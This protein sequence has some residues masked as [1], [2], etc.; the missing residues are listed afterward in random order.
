MKASRFF[1]WLLALSLLSASFPVFAGQAEVEKGLH[2]SLKD[3]NRIIRQIKSRAFDGKPVQKQLEQLT[4]L[5]D[6]LETTHLLIQERHRLRLDKAKSLGGKAARR[7]AAMA[8]RYGQA[9]DEL[10]SLLAQLQHDGIND[11]SLLEQ[12]ETLLLQFTPQQQ[13]PLHGILPYHHLDYPTVSPLSSPTITPV[14]QA[15][16]KNS[17]SAD[18]QGSAE[19]PVSALIA[20]HAKTIAVAAGTQNWDPV[21]IYEW[22]K[23]NIETEWYFGVMKGAEETLRQGSGNDADQATL[24]VALLRASGYPTRYVRGVIEF[25]PGIDTRSIEG[26]VLL[27]FQVPYFGVRLTYDL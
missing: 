4:L 24:L 10:L 14:Y 25:F 20:G 3:C 19:A 23:N 11:I 2:G 26:W 22:V 1:T 6:D 13:L 16:T 21:A 27:Y 8:E 18:L 12:I 15:G 17:N 7:Q 9:M 5:L